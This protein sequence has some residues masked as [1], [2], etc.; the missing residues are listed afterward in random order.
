LGNAAPGESIKTPGR[1]AST[2]VTLPSP[3]LANETGDKLEKEA[4]RGSENKSAATEVLPVNEEPKDESSR[5]DAE[6][7][8]EGVVEEHSKKVEKFE[9]VQQI[10]SETFPKA[11]QGEN[12]DGQVCAE[13]ITEQPK[14]AIPSFSSDA[15]EIEQ[16]A[17]PE[18]PTDEIECPVSSLPSPPV[19]E[20]L[21]EKHDH[22][23]VGASEQRERSEEVEGK[24]KDQQFSERAEVP[25]TVARSSD[26]NPTA[27]NSAAV[28]SGILGAVTVS[29]TKILPAVPGVF[30]TTQIP[31]VAD[32]ENPVIQ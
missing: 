9:V 1:H 4:T 11:Q 20:T 24:C 28:V 31:L 6:Q 25:P 13:S 16:D 26:D 30:E 21:A 14:D 23:A 17:N 10:A 27:V 18:P 12:A 5:K 7:D 32:D 15:G 3:V 22:A 2:P 29:D 19:P 8:T